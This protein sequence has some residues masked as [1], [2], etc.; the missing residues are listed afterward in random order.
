MTTNKNYLCPESLE[1]V[2]KI[3]IP[4]IANG[5]GKVMGCSSSLMSQQ[6]RVLYLKTLLIYSDAIY[7]SLQHLTL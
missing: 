7:E 3:S 1:K 5:H 2:P 4:Q 6:L